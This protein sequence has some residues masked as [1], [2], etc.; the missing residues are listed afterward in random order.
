M[1]NI[2]RQTKELMNQELLLIYSSLIKDL[3]FTLASASVLKG[4]DDYE[5]EE[6]LSDDICEQVFQ[7][8][9]MFLSLLRRM[10]MDFALIYELDEQLGILQPELIDDINQIMSYKEEQKDI[11]YSPFNP[12]END[13]ED[14]KNCWH[15]FLIRLVSTL[16]IK[17]VL[18]EIS[19]GIEE[20]GVD[21]YIV[22]EDAVSIDTLENIEETEDPSLLSEALNS[23][24]EKTEDE[25]ENE[26]RLSLLTLIKSI[27]K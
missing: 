21:P 17:A 9:E 15:E 12:Y 13:K 7:T 24:V 10:P 8:K 23:L 3:A 19:A 22:P 20:Y 11:V 27:A 6:R 18:N 4:K 1:K 26:N 14:N 25:E 16:R 2:T 5:K